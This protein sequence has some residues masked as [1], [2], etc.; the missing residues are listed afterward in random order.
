[1]ADPVETPI[2]RVSADHF[3]PGH[4]RHQVVLGPK[5][6]YALFNPSDRMHDVSKAL[7]NFVRDGAL[8]YLHL[9]VNEHII[10]EAATRLKK[11][12]S[13]RNATAFLATLDESSLYRL[14]HTPEAVFEAATTRFSEW[15]DLPA[16]F[17][18]F[19]VATHMA[20]LGIDHIATYDSHYAAFD[21]TT[22]PYRR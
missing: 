14:E 4:V 20:D 12:A 7:M 5:F 2:G 1:M 21:V 19:V 17:T 13:I 22:L 15:T 10:D 6:L 8:P 9:L 3:R 11:K 18:D 16:S